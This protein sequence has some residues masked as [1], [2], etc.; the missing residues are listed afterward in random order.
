VKVAAGYIP[1]SE[2]V[3]EVMKLDVVAK[4]IL[5]H[6]ITAIESCSSGQ[7]CNVMKKVMNPC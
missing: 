1:K 7:Y 6:S 3:N 2:F 5:K 4:V